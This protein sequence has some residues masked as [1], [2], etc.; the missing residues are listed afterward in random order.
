MHGPSS[1]SDLIAA[2]RALIAGSP[3]RGG[4]GKSILRVTVSVPRVCWRDCVAS[5]RNEIWPGPIRARVWSLE[6]E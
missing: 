2:T 3:R 5:S 4:G 1:G 6:V